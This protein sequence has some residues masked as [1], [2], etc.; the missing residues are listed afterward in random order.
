MSKNTLRLASK[1]AAVF[2]LVALP[3]FGI[4]TLAT[5]PSAPVA[6]VAGTTTDTETATTNGGA[7]TA[8]APTPT[9]SSSKDTTGWD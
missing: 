5:Q 4:A 1:F 3:T 8:A 6:T 2:A 9:P 7:D